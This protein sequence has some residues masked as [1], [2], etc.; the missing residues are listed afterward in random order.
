MS[1]GTWASPSHSGSVKKVQP[2][3]ASSSSLSFKS[4]SFGQY[5]IISCGSV[6]GKFYPEKYKK[7]LP[8]SKCVH[9]NSNWCSLVEFEGFGGKNKSKNWKKSVKHNGTS[10]GSILDS[11][12][13]NFP[14]VMD[15]GSC[16]TNTIPPSVSTPSP[17]SVIAGDQNSQASISQQVLTMPLLCCPVLAFIKGYRLRGDACSLKQSLVDGFSDS[18]LSD[19]MKTLWNYCQ[20]KLSSMD[21]SYHVRRATD[22][23]PVNVAVID[24]LLSAFDKLDSADSIP[25]IYCEAVD[26]LGLPSLSL[27][28]TKSVLHDTCSLVDKLHTNFTDLSSNLSTFSSSFDSLRQQFSS[29]CTSLKDSFDNAL[30]SL[31]AEVKS[32]DVKVNHVCPSTNASAGPTSVPSSQISSMSKSKSQVIDRSANLIFFGLPEDS[33]VKTREIVDEISNFLVGSDARIK[34]LFRIGKR[35]DKADAQSRPTI[36]KFSTVWDKRLLLAAK[37]KLKSFRLQRIFIRQDM[38]KE[39]R[40]VVSVKRRAAR[41]AASGSN[42]DNSLITPLSP[43]SHSTSDMQGSASQFD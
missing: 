42:P 22:K 30:S 1:F 27:A 18:A 8:S 17:S 13:G 25:P 5:L 31:S 39:E 34:D 12:L 11:I 19:A 32:L 2:S 37:A 35:L 36:V 21:V 33:L 14:D 3:F 41:S 9:F 26:L 24:D 16:L 40:L 4:D 28:D 43:P 7:G 38:S 20:D 23:R 15:G 29:T 6:E 10:L